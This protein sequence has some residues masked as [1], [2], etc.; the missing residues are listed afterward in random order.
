MADE[1]C[2]LL[3]EWLDLVS[4]LSEIAKQMDVLMPAVM[5]GARM[6]LLGSMDTTA[7][8]YEEKKE[9]IYLFEREVIG[10]WIIK[11]SNSAVGE[12]AGIA[13]MSLAPFAT[14]LGTVIDKNI[15]TVVR[16]DTSNSWDKQLEVHRQFI[17]KFKKD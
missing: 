15:L 14:E 6:L 1:E 3:E 16:D 10:A 8:G 5:V 13:L 2:E 9:M 12:G 17:K 7:P 4:R 11:H